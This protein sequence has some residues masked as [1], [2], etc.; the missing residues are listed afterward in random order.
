MKQAYLLITILFCA[1][2]AHMDL[3]KPIDTV[4]LAEAAF[5]GDHFPAG[6]KIS[7][8]A[9]I[10]RHGERPTISFLYPE[11]AELNGKD[12]RSYGFGAHL[13]SH[14]SL[15]YLKEE[16]PVILDA[17]IVN[18]GQ[19]CYNFYFLYFESA[20]PLYDSIGRPMP[21]FPEKYKDYR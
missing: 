5:H 15:E 20:I 7:V 11:G 8:I 4:D 6:T 9:Q 12:I 17:I 13:T 19:V 21:D 2:C 14:Q 18:G 1:G 10:T 16:R 3:A